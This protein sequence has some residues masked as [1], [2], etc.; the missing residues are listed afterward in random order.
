MSA[1]GRIL[2]EGCGYTLSQVTSEVLPATC[3]ECGSPCESSL[4]ARRVLP[5]WERTPGPCAWCRTACRVLVMPHT[6]FKEIQVHG[7]SSRPRLF[8][9]ISALSV[10]LLLT[11]MGGASVLLQNP[12]AGRASVPPVWWWL[13]GMGAVKLTLLLSYI[14]VVGVT[15]IGR[16]RGWRFSLQGAERLVAYASLGF[17]VGVLVA[18]PL[19][20][21]TPRAVA[22]W[23]RQPGWPLLPSGA[24]LWVAVML[25]LW[26]PTLVFSFYLGVGLR[27]ARFA[28]A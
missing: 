17:P 8:L 27:Q 14:E 4:P 1:D 24:S 13:I 11:S 18:S 22:A 23:D 15:L 28:N 26:V 2:C 12:G 20:A 9:L 21:L 10:G 5:S 16:R 6:F 3:P 7:R 19:V 25:S